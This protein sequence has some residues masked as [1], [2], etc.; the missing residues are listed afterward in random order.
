MKSSN[1]KI[2]A[3]LATFTM[4]GMANYSQSKYHEEP[5]LS[6]EL[7]DDYDKRTAKGHLHLNDRGEIIIPTGGLHQCIV[8]AAKYSKE[9][10]KGQGMAT[11]TAK[12]SSGVAIIDDPVIQVDSEAKVDP[13]V[14]V[15]PCAGVIYFPCWANADG[16]RG[17]GK[18]V[19]RRYPVIPAGWTAKVQIWVLDPIITEDQFSKTMNMAGKFIGIGRWRP[20]NLGQNG[21]FT[22]RDLEWDDN[23]DFEEAL[24][25]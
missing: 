21:R 22:I 24:K 5:K 6:G 12:F 14:E 17:S 7:H 18:R 23:R 4:F 16:V 15:D 2:K 1:G 11:W 9:R 13:E 10:I 19:M 25:K 20:E 3:S 8:S